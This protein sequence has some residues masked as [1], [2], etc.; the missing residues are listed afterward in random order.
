MC[1]CG[2]FPVCFSLLY[3]GLVLDIEGEGTGEGGEEGAGGSG[4]GGE[5]GEGGGRGSVEKDGNPVIQCLPLYSILAAL[6]NPT[7]H[8]FR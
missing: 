1:I 7:V 3:E 6:G 2:N 8:Y 4:V 5:G